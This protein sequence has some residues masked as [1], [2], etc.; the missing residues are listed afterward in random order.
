MS[1]VIVNK[2]AQSSLVTLDLEKLFP[3]EEIIPFDLKNYL[4]MDLILKEK[5][6]RQAMKELDWSV[7]QNKSIALYCSA[8]VIIPLWAYMLVTVNAQP[9]ASNIMFGNKEEVAEKLLV[10]NI[11][12]VNIHDY[13]DARVV[14]KG[15]G[16]L[17]IPAAAYIRITER[18][19]PVAKSIMFGEPCSTVPVY[20]Q[21][22]T[23]GN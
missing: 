19:T 15:C 4:F 2:V 17:K 12:L 13:K 10:K 6:F 3:K 22:K 8:D 1:A 5:D 16:K 14:V 18:L 9:F 21:K 23:P 20:K 11:D 7:Y